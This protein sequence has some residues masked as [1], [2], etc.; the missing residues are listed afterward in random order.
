MSDFEDRSERVQELMKE[1][2][3]EVDQD[4]QDAFEMNN[5]TIETEESQFKLNLEMRKA[6]IE[7]D[8]YG[9]N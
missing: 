9:W 5:V 7:D 4:S 3:E 1:I 2:A 6:S 8:Y